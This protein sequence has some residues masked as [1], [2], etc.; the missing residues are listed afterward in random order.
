[1]LYCDKCNVSIHGKKICCP[2]CGNTVSGDADPDVFPITEKPKVKA[3]LLI[4]IISFVS[5]C[6]IVICLTVNLLVSNDFFWSL[7]ASAAVASVWISS[8]VGITNRKNVL[9][10]ITWQLFI[11]SAAAVLWDVCTGWHGWSIDYVIPLGCIASM[12]S[13]FIS[14]L[15]LHKPPMEFLT[16]II[17][18]GIYGITPIIFYL[19]GI[20]NQPLPSILCIA[21]SII[22]I[23]GILIFEGKNIRKQF[24]RKLHL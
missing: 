6:A 16:Y 17:F 10:N 24:S 3:T 5:I 7:F 19:T 22:F 11:V 13:M 21:T 8:V 2:L 18:D 1:M 12:L 23:S 20:L 15:I 14:S 9:K 4:K